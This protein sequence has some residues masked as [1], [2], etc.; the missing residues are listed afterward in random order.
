MPRCWFHQLLL[1]ITSSLIAACGAWETPRAWPADVPPRNPAITGTPITLRVW[2]AAD[3][4]DTAPIR[5]LFRDFERAYPNIRIEPTSGILWEEMRQ[6]IE[7]AVSQGNPPDL[8]HG[9]AFAFGALGL[10][11]P[12]DEAWRAWNVE[13]EFMP[14]A[15]EDVIW[16]GRHYGVP[17]DIN[18]LFTIYNKRLLREAGLPEPVA[19]WT[20]ADLER[21]AARL[22]ESDGSQYGLALSASGWAMAGMINAAG[23]DLLTER[24]GRIVATIDTPPVAETLWLHRR[25]GLERHHG[26][27][28]PPIMRQSDHPVRLFAAGKVAMFF[29]GPWDLARLRQEAPELLADVGTAPLPRGQGPNAGGSVQGGGSLFVPSGARHPE[30]AFEVMKW[31]VAD[32]YARRLASELGRYPVRT[33]LYEDPAMRSDPLL[34]PFFE[35]LTTARPY[36]LEAYQRANELWKAAVSAVFDP[37]ADLDAVIRQTQDGIQAA[38]DEV[39]QA[40]QRRFSTSQ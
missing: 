27:L 34:Q 4:V 1:I 38:I 18:T 29:S 39:E 26:T 14:G 15:M 35:Q 32:P 24:D 30:A 9:H 11:Q 6:R 8:A 7:L 36:K 20:F 17:L 25:L 13:N 10:A 31:A 23:G 2:L 21:M 33:R 5:D 22:T 19:G 37:N 28:P 40:S 3:Y 12:L 16:K